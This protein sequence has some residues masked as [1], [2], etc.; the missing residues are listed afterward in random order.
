VTLDFDPLTTIAFHSQALYDAADETD[1][2]TPVAHCPGWTVA[3]L[4]AHVNEVHAF[5]ATIVE[6]P[7]SEPPEDRTDRPSDDR[8]IASGR[9]Q[10]KRLVD[11][12]EAADP[13]AR[14]W[15][16]APQQDVAFVLRHQ[17]QEAAVHHFDAAHAAGL[18]WE[19]DPVAAADAVSE[20]LTFSLSDEDDPAAPLEGSF[21]LQ[22]RD[23]GHTWTVRDGS[24][25]G[26]LA[27]D[28]GPSSAPAV[29]GT[30]AE[31]LLWLYR[32]TELDTSAVP[33]ELL[34]RFDPLRFTD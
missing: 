7:L 31:L 23:T 26:T 1:L 28:V 14:C 29:E 15:T 8:L 20:F 25:P 27:F 32:R 3:D 6:G 11:A 2:A 19:M 12:L 17:V 9:E 22:A 34:A 21:A 33:S 4:L 16:W 18:G 5:W 24:A 13:G 10:A 30:A